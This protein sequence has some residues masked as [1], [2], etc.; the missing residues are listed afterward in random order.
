MRTLLFQCGLFGLAVIAFC[1]QARAQASDPRQS[2]QPVA[3]TGVAPAAD[4]DAIRRAE[5]EPKVLTLFES[6]RFDEALLPARELLEI[7]TRVHGHTHWRTLIAKSNLATIEKLTSIPEASA[8]MQEARR[9]EK[10]VAK[11][12]REGRYGDAIPIA[13]RVVSIRQRLLGDDHQIVATSLNQQGICC[14]SAG[15]YAQAETLFRKALEITQRVLSDDHPQAA[16][17]YGNLALSLQRQDKYSEATALLQK[18]LRIE[19]QVNGPDHA[20]AAIAY[21]NVAS[22]F[23]HQGLYD[24]AEPLYRQALD[25]LRQSLGEDHEKTAMAHNN[26]GFNLHRQAKDVDADREYREALRI[27][28]KLSQAAHPDTGLVYNNLAVSLADQGRYADAEPLYRKALEIYG[29]TLGAD[30]PQT[31]ATYNNLALALSNQG[32]LAEAESLFRRALDRHAAATR[33]RESLSTATWRTNLA[34]NLKGQGRYAEAKEMLDRALAIHQRILGEDHVD[35]AQSYNNLAAYF[36]KQSE[37]DQAESLIRK[38]LRII[39]QQLGDDHP[40]TAMAHGNLAVILYHQG[41]Y[42]E[43]DEFQQTSLGIY[44]RILGEGHPN[45]TW[46]LLNSAMLAWARGDYRAA[47]QHGIQGAK[48]FDVARIRIS[49]AGLERASFAADTSPW[50]L[51]AALA[52]RNGKP[53]EAWRAL[54]NDL[55]R[56][57][58]DDLAARPLTADERNRE[59][60][61]LGRLNR[62]DGQ[63]AALLGT[64][65]EAARLK[66]EQLSKERDDLQSKLSQFQAELT[67]KYGFAVGE[68]YDLHRI[69]SRLAADTALLTWLDLP[70]QDKGHDP[71]GE[72][73]A[74]VLRQQG[75]P[76]W[77]R[78]AGSGAERAW[79]HVDE[80]LS[81]EF[82]QLCSTRPTSSA[83]EGKILAKKLHAQRLLPLEDYLTANDGLPAVQHLIV[84]PAKQMRGVPIETLTDRYTI[85]YVPSATLFA[86][87]QEKRVANENGQEPVDRSILAVGDPAFGSAE[88]SDSLDE[89]TRKSGHGEFARLQG[90][91]SEVRAVARFF[92]AATVLIG[93]EASKQNL[94]ML[95]EKGQLA[96]FR[97][98]HFATHGILD[99]QSPMRSAL[100]LAQNRL[101][102]PDQTLA[103]PQVQESRLTAEQILRSWRLDAD[104]VVLSACDTGLGKYTGGEGYI[105]FSQAL[106][107]AGARS[108]VLSLW[109]VDDISTALLMSRFYENLTGARPGQPQM[110]KAMALAEAKHWLRGL[111]VDE[112][113]QILSSVQLGV[114]LEQARGRRVPKPAK[115]SEAPAAVYPY[116]HPYYWSGFILIGDSN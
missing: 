85:S 93:Q 76:A 38:A 114:S 43:A 3:E 63:I 97:F 67:A 13:A 107:L 2:K 78:L 94:D 59:L 90:S 108:L 28:L 87:L 98:L 41:K 68:V 115:Q 70:G 48:S 60:S 53:L 79:T 81:A 45:T 55:A 73:W 33:D 88:P 39:Q 96:K 22:N 104:L 49:Y 47:E 110:G 71:N 103:S 57:L 82:R 106:F 21:T 102:R 5:L 11:L 105:G 4:D 109:Q 74:C 58:L 54:E 72:H 112:T 99:E 31:L 42:A 83:G 15:Q 37:Y 56:G 24:K 113:E 50:P 29:Q 14:H 35:T 69:Q 95:L 100:I 32:K 77:I 23:D 20:G 34:H 10:E 7:V 27:R 9:L 75:H 65:T 17:C 116:A 40:L 36:Y 12:A 101:S 46:A 66:S 89:S 92:P 64:R 61:F 18:A 26:L 16:A 1:Q 80:S 86:W 62:L 19:L 52:A 91:E 51:V 25:V 8:E 84:L 6:S 30:H 44:Q 111:T